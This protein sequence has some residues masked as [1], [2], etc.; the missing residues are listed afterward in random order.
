VLQAYLTDVAPPLI[1]HSTAPSE[2]TDREFSADL[3]ELVEMLRASVAP[4]HLRLVLLIDEMDVIDS[5]D[6]LAQLQLR[7]IFMS[8]LAENLGAVVAGIQISKSW[9]R[10]ESPWFNLFNEFA[11]EPFDDDQARE[12][13][14]EPVR[15]VYEWEP[16]ATDFVVARAEGRPHRLQQI[17]LEAVDHMLSAGRLRI[18]LEDVQAA[19]AIIEHARAD[20][21]A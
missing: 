1:F 2:Y 18:T 5:Y 11:L 10:V 19:D 3:R 7:R 4:R 9:D 16:A 20:T 6:R 14:V 12:L 13:L 17:A 21:S 8:P 15:G